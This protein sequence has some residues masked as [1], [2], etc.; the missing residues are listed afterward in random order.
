MALDGIVLKNIIKELNTTILYGKI[1]KIYQPEKDKIIINIYNK[2]NTYKLLIS[3][4]SNNPRI[5]LTRNLKQNPPNPPMFCMLLRKH[6]TGGIIQNIEQF[7]LDRV[8]FIDI[9]SIDELGNTVI[10]R[11]VVEIM[12]KYSNIILIDKDSSKVIDSIKRV[13]SSMSRIREVLPGTYYSLP[14]QDDKVNPLI[15]DREQFINLIN[16]QDKNKKIYKFFYENYMGLSPLISKEICYLSNIDMDRPI[17]ILSE[18][19]IQNLFDAF[20]KIVDE[21]NNENFN[22]ILIKK[23]Y[24]KEYREFYCLNINQ[25]GNDNK[26][27]MNSINQVLDQYYSINDKLDRILQKSQSLKKAVQTKLEKSLN[28]LSKQKQ[29]LLDSEKREI[30]KIYADLISANLYRIEKGLEEIELENFYD[31]NLEKIKIPLDKKLTPVENAQRYYKK[32]NKLKNAHKLL[33][34]QIPETE[35]EIEYLENVLNSLDNCT[36]VIE[37]EEI[38]EEL[39]KEGYIKGKISKN[40]AS[41]K[42]KPYHFISSDGFHIYVGKNNKQNDMLTLKTAKKDDLWFHAQNMPGSHVIV[43]TENNQ[44]PDST[45]L[46][47]ALLA[48]YYSKGKNSNNV[49]VDY[50]ERRNVKKPKDAKAGMVIYE[51]YRTIFVTPDKEKIDKIKRIEE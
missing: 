32:Y 9:S 17:G 44:V 21:I 6:L 50:T 4:S 51:N 45:L 34:S 11:L 25:F 36:E 28:K 39:I 49:P 47:A 46:E 31:E 19:D 35:K 18:M 5:H 1:D 38:K 22:P 41:T 10:K 33:L 3:A 7:E 23:E 43:R 48:A 24:G 42:S 12:G 16:S 15:V 26:I 20:M 14:K 8:A 30:Y 29:E 37:I 40:K 2:G 13:T 27:H